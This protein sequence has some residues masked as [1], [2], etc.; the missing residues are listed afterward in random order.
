MDIKA[1]DIIVVG[2]IIGG[3]FYWWPQQ[4]VEVERAKLEEERPSEPIIDA[5]DVVAIKSETSKVVK[6][7]K[8]IP[9]PPVVKKT[10]STA[11]YP[12]LDDSF[13]AFDEQGNRFIEQVNKVG[14]HLVY[15][16]DVLIGDE[17]DLPG[18]MQNRV[19]KVA[20]SAKWPQGKIPFVIDGSVVQQE[21][22]IEAVE[23]LNTFT[24][25][26]IVPRENEED[27]VLFTRGESDCYSYAG[28]KGGM[29]EVF[30]TPQCGIREI[31]H[32]WMHTIGF[33]HEQNRE[34]RDQ[35]VQILWDNIEEVNRPQ[36][37]K[38]PND[39]MGVVGRPFDYQ[40]IMM[41]SSETFSMFPGEPALL[42]SDGEV[43]PRT[44]NLLSDEDIARINQ[45]YPN[46]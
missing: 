2:V 7:P 11:K 26:K 37:K 8:K 41:Y 28:R 13:A 40:S 9:M 36:F 17:K 16:G 3:F 10:S 12:N 1:R 22:V 6:E 32:E 4:K 24:N 39:Y 19:I 34:D 30:L 27:Y 15:H 25:L 18:L 42:T 35:Y 21:K 5:R 31:L 29:Q 46:Q 45:G 38:L 14:K 43:I 44:S 23:Y 20:R 33:L